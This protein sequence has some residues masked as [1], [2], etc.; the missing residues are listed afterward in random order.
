[1]HHVT[2]VKKFYGGEHLVLL[3]AARWDQ[4]AVNSKAGWC[5]RSFLDMTTTKLLLELDCVVR[6]GTFPESVVR[7]HSY[8]TRPRP[9][10]VD[11]QVFVGLL[12]GNKLSSCIA[13]AHS[14][15]VP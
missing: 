8:V 9:A 7:V 15:D 6:L 11:K 2:F 4:P 5:G 12:L 13:W 3:V 1:M 14:L 10:G